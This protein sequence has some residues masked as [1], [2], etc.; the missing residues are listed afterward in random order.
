MKKTYVRPSMVCEVF[1]ADEYV[2]ACGDSGTNYNF[3]CDAGGGVTGSVYQETNGKEGF[4][5]GITGIFGGDKL[6][7]RSYYAC[8]KSHVAS[9][10]DEFLEGYYVNDFK[11]VPVI[12]WRG[13]W[14]NNVHCTTN[15]DIDSWE[16][17]KS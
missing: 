17:A 11:V 13:K 14:G 7:A 9:S 16:T 5:P 10:K 12:I 8:N 6:L 3:T 1:A 4:Q 15:L 2:A